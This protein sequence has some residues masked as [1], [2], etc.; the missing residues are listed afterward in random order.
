MVSGPGLFHDAGQAGPGPIG[1]GLKTMVLTNTM[2]DKAF[3]MNL[4]RIPWLL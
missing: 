2:G 3:I 4:P 1:L